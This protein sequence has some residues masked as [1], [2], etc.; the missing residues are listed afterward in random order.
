MDPLERKLDTLIDKLDK[1]YSTGG[2]ANIPQSNNSTGLETGLKDLFA[3]VGKGVGNVFDTTQGLLGKAQAN[4]ATSQD[5]ASAVAK[6]V[7]QLTAD[8]PGLSKF[9][10][11]FQGMTEVLTE[12]VGNWQ[13]FS[14]FGLQFGGDAIALNTAIKRTGMSVDQFA[15]QW[16]RL[17]PSIYNLGLGVTAGT[18]AY[19]ELSARMLEPQYADQF[20]K[21]GM[22]VKDTN[23]ALA[24][25]I[26][27]ANGIIDF[28][29]KGA[30]EALLQSTIQLGKEMDA[31]AKL[32]GKA[33]D[34]QLKQIDALQAS[35]R[36]NA[37]ILLNREQN[38]AA[39]ADIGRAQ[40]IAGSRLDPETAKLINEGIAGKGIFT[41][42]AI[43]QFR[44]IFGP[45][46][47]TRASQITRDINSTDEK[48]RKAALENLEQFNLQLMN[49]RR[50]G[51]GIT[52][53]GATE[54]NKFAEVAYGGLSNQYE[55]QRKNIDAI[56]EES[57]NK[58]MTDEAA[59]A[60]AMNRIR[61]LEQQGK[62]Q[63]IGPDGKLK[64]VDIPGAQLT[65]AVTGAETNIKRFGVGL[66]E[67]IE[68]MTNSIGKM[69]GKNGQTVAAELEAKTNM[70]ISPTKSATTEMMNSINAQLTRMEAL[71]DKWG[72]K[73]GEAVAEHIKKLMESTKHEGGT[74]GVKG[75]WFEDFGSKSYIQTEG[76]ESVIREDQADAFAMSRMNNI[77][78]SLSKIMKNKPATVSDSSSGADQVA[79]AISKLTT[80]SMP[81]FSNLGEGID[82][83][84]STF[85]S[86]GPVLQQIARNTGEAA[87][88]TKDIGNYIS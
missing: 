47:A 42:D 33:K 40:Q 32:T 68:T 85:E 14:G 82:K 86:L 44:Q 41:S 36:V 34:E 38:P 70:A 57:K 11:V 31:M 78:P 61:M 5:V 25:V 74:K 72:E 51:A 46:A 81:D 45:E 84:N 55:I 48:T 63:E 16:E 69:K 50:S 29:K 75:T 27:G 60:E 39:N 62:K 18:K 35:A 8:I 13:K 15:E 53:G 19:G 67:L 88:N 20:N 76:V 21:L 28:Q 87:T 73:I 77:M 3:S 4:T 71:P 43:V 58:D 52:A 7:S 64:V 12:S 83:L 23:A 22:N 56:K 66:N 59:Y 37:R 17:G 1:L 2:R 9:G 65:S 79:E 30:D 49:S 24:T 26:R 80:S 6:T 54:G 10:Q